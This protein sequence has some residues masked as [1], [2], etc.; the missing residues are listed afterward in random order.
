MFDS[1]LDRGA[2]PEQRFGAGVMFTAAVVAI[3]IP[4][5]YLLSI[6]K[7]KV[8]KKEQDVVFMQRQAA[9]PPD[10]EALRPC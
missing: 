2:V 8:V 6:Q 9:A 7:T 3:M 1:V 10:I 4:A 5:V